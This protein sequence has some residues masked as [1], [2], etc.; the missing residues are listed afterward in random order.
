MI[1]LFI[2]LIIIAILAALGWGLLGMLKG[3]KQGSDKMFKS[4]VTRVVLSLTL[5]ALVMFAAFMGW[6]EPNNVILDAADL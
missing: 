3:G 1:E 5:F 2:V 6:I 4:I